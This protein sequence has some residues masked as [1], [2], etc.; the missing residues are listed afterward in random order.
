MFILGKV[1]EAEDPL[2]AEMMIEEKK[3]KRRE[4]NQTG[5]RVKRHEA[6]A[7]PPGDGCAVEYGGGDRF[8]V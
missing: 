5:G 6:R 1:P 2:P 8:L 4:E 3:K 7:T